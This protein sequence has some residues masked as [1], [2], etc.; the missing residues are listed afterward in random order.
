M[1]FVL[2]SNSI[3]RC[4]T[5]LSQKE[6]VHLIERRFGVIVTQFSSSKSVWSLNCQKKIDFSSATW[7]KLWPITVQTM[8]MT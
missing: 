6:N 7:W 3:V 1:S 8:G 4:K 5:N 2:I